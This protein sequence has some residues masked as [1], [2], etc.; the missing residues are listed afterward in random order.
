[1]WAW[2]GFSCSCFSCAAPASDPATP[3]PGGEGS[4]DDVGGEDEDDEEE[5]DGGGE[6]DV[7]RK[8]RK[9]GLSWSTKNNIDNDRRNK[10]PETSCPR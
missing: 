3:E 8:R 2:E 9:E 4:D 1:M 10:C 6:D 7:P 5:E